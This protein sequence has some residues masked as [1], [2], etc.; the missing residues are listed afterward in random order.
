MTM[1]TRISGLLLGLVLTINA[2]GQ[3]PNAPALG[4]VAGPVATAYFI[5]FKVKPG[6]N[7]DFEKAIS[8][9]MVGV[10]KKEPRNVYCDLLHLAQDAQTY[11]IVERYKDAEA[12][13]AHV[14]SEYIKKL[15][16]ALKNDLLDGPPEPQELVFI[17][18]K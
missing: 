5:K 1:R 16:D 2:Y 8:E 11:V 6:K 3:P 4:A 18:S 15:G 12:S 9:M 10:R 17:R 14:E 13:K 7:A